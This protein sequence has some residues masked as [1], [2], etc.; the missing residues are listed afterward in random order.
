MIKTVQ[1]PGCGESAT[2]DE[3]NPARFCMSCGHRL[4]EDTAQIS[5]QMQSYPAP[6]QVST[7][8]FQPAPI[9]AFP[10]G[11]NLIVSYSSEHPRVNMVITFI[12]TR[13]RERYVNGTTKAY[14]LVPGMHAINFTIGK[15]TYR[16]DIYISPD[17]RPVTVQASWHRGVARIAIMNPTAGNIPMTY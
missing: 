4:F 12:S 5:S 11:T 6:G 3:S 2:F 13:F 9:M 7:P 1:C 8:A 17:G 16:R 15:R 14:C 10:Q